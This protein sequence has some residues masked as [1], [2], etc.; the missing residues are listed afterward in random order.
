ML[1]VSKSEKLDHLKYS[2]VAAPPNKLITREHYPSILNEET[3]LYELHITESKSKLQNDS[4][5]KPSPWKI[6]HKLI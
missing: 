1:I 3:G 4:A 5:E 6:L 2:S